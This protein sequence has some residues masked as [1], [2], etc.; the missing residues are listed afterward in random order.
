MEDRGIP[1]LLPEEGQPHPRQAQSLT[2]EK[3]EQ[4]EHCK[5]EAARKLLLGIKE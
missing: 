5:T 3:L 2:R 1:F 4:L